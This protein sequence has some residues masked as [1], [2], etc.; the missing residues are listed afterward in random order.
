[1]KKATTDLGYSGMMKV[2]EIKGLK[3]LVTKSL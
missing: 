3:V 2:I 1:M